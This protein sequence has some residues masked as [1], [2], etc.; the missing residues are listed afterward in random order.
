MERLEGRMH[1]RMQFGEFRVEQP[2][3]AAAASLK[4]FNESSKESE[5]FPRD[6]ISFFQPPATS[7]IYS[8]FL[9]CFLN[10]STFM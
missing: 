2:N 4:I 9:F 5:I 1:K 10:H 6:H 3:G 8:F 7:S